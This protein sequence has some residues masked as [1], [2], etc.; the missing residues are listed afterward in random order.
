VIT[1]F[2]RKLETPILID[3]LEEDSQF[4]TLPLYKLTLELKGKVDLVP[5]ASVKTT[6][7][8]LPGQLRDLVPQLQA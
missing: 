4:S 2:L 5:R 1:H 6:G 3:F 8:L 7:L